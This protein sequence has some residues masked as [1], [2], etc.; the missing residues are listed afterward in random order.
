MTE[1]NTKKFPATVVEIIN[2]YRVVINRGKLDGIQLGQPFLIYILSSKEIIDPETQDS[3]GYLEIVKGR[4][5]VVHIQERMATIESSI[6][7]APIRKVVKKIPTGPFG[8]IYNQGEELEEII[9]G[10][11][12]APFDD[13]KFGDKAKPV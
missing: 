11:K 13:P 3:L 1:T 8:F 5:K 10:S 6:T 7:T 4:G 12:L 9:E 2:E